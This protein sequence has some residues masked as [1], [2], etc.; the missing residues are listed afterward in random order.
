MHKIFEWIDRMTYL[1]PG[2][3]IKITGIGLAILW[4]FTAVILSTL[5]WNKGAEEAYEVGDYKRNLLKFQE[6]V[7]RER[8]LGKSSTI[9]LPE[10]KDLPEELLSREV[11]AKDRERINT[12]YELPRIAPISNPKDSKYEN[13]N[14]NT[15]QLY[16]KLPIMQDTQ[17]KNIKNNQLESKVTNEDIR[18]SL[19]GIS[20]VEDVPILPLPER[21]PKKAK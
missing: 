14:K 12:D 13:S 6:K 7:K 19:E 17:T 1:L 2:P 5:F 11:L 4:L 16:E 9:I 15:K 20:G 21:V 3:L 10:L 8:N 18:D